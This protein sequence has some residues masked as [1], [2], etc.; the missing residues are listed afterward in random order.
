MNL[1]DRIRQRLIDLNMSQEALGKAIGVSQVAIAKVIS[2]KT[3]DPKKI[4]EMAKALEV[5]ADWLK[6]GTY[7]SSENN[8]IQLA[9]S[10]PSP[11]KPSLDQERIEK[12]FTFI[13]K[14]IGYG[15]LHDEGT[16][17]SSDIFIKLYD[18]YGDPGSEGL[19]SETILKIIM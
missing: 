7:H 19:N 8:G 17:W 13:D 15:V 1:G 16:K 3:K 2:G 9:C 18:L 10:D 11:Y 5:D 6:T 12:C 14:E 4:L